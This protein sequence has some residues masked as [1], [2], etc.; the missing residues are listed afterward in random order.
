LW[1]DFQVNPGKFILRYAKH[2]HEFS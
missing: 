1:E 2:P